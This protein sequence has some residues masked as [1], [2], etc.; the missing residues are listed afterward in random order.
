MGLTPK[1]LAL[2]TAGIAA[3][4]MRPNIVFG[5]STKMDHADHIV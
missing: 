2:S 1:D 5:E 4:E 3:F